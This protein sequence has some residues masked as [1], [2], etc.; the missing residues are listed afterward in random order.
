M[1]VDGLDHNIMVNSKFI[2]KG[3]RIAMDDKEYHL[4]VNEII[5][6]VQNALDVDLIGISDTERMVQAN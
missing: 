2:K 3:D 1:L 6:K 5:D 4:K